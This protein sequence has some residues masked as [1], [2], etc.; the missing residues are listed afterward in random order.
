MDIREIL[1]AL[2]QIAVLAFAIYWVLYYLRSSRSSL[3]LFALVGLWVAFSILSKLLQ[4]TVISRLLDLTGYS[5]IIVLFVLFQPELRRALAQLG[6][7]FYPHNRRRRE[8]IGEI[9]SAACNMAYRKCGALMV[10][11]RKI[12]LQALADDAVALECK[13]NVLRTRA[14]QIRSARWPSM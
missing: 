14:R 12:R 2:F 9:V 7:I 3:V 6:S 11:E 1:R 4:L 5:L 13:V 8:V 10:I